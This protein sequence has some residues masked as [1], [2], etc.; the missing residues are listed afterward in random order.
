MARGGEGRERKVPKCALFTGSTG[1][2]S[3]HAKIKKHG[4]ICKRFTKKLKYAKYACNM[5]SF[6]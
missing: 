5:H 3:K 6:A 4:K 2:A 1:M